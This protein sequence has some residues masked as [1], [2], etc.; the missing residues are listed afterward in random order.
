MN[1]LRILSPA[2]TEMAAAARYY[3]SQSGGL[4]RRFLRHVRRTVDSIVANPRAGATVRGNVRRRIVRS[5][6]FSVLYCVE[7]EEILVIA[8]MDLRRDPEYWLDRI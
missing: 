1:S 4:G 7:P 8:V 2:E 6:P 5:F 3:E